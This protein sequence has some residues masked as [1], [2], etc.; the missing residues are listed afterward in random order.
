[1]EEPQSAQSAQSG[2][3]I[4]F[5]GLFGNFVNFFCEIWVWISVVSGKLLRYA[6]RS[7]SKTK[8]EKLPAAAVEP[9]NNSATK[10]YGLMMV[11]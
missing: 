7:G 3:F 4:I 8:E 5:V 9:S 1:M 2:K 6:L 11:M 10:R